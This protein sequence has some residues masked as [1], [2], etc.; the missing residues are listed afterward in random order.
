MTGPR[1]PV[2]RRPGASLVLGLAGATGLI[3]LVRQVGPEPIEATLRAARPDLLALALALFGVVALGTTLRWGA[4]LAVL[5]S[6]PAVFRLLGIRLAGVA[7]GALTP[8][9]KL[10]GEP[11]RAWLVSREGVA[12]G[13]A[14]A[15]VVVDRGL[16]LAANLV[17]AVVY[18]GFFADRDAT[19]A[20]QV[21]M[22]LLAVGAAFVAGAVFLVR[23]LGSGRR[24]VPERFAPVLARLGRSGNVL[25]ATDHA[26][27][28]LL[29][30]HRPLLAIAFGISLALNV[31]VALEVA[32]L[33]AA[34]GVHLDLA[35]L[36]GSMLGIGVAHALPL[37]GS[38]GAL[39][40]A[41]VTFLAAAGGGRQIQITGA[42]VS[43]VRDLVW[44]LPGLAW[45]A[46]GRVRSGS[47]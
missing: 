30:E 44:T 47:R 38:L 15:S 28:G 37:P 34:F 13:A 11:L 18:C 23:R 16:E 7:V 42:I 36:S 41:Q 1:V 21:L 25:A 43:R 40:G 5:G 39:E 2:W 31:L 33:F 22:F 10:G 6:R 9:A 19:T 4:L 46:T 24:L 27:R 45:L 8:G 14:V 12:A 20:G 29:V 17:F 26:L 32:V 35:E 3:L